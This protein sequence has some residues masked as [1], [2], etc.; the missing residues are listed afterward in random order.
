MLD[1]PPPYPSRRHI[2]RGRLTRPA[3]AWPVAGALVIVIVATIGLVTYRG[4]RH[5]TR[6]A[7]DPVTSGG[8]AGQASGSDLP[9]AAASSAAPSASPSASRC[10][11]SGC[12]GNPGA[13]AAGA[14]PI[15]APAGKRWALTFGEEF[16]G[17]DYDHGKLTPCFDWNT[18]ECT[19]TFNNG[20]EAYQP[21]QVKVSNG[22][23]KLVAQ[24]AAKPI[25]SSSCQGG[26]CT[27]VAGLLST[28]RPKAAS[29]QGYL[30]KFTYGF[31]ES[32]FKFPATR[33]FFT[34]FWMLPADPSYNYR[35]E[36]DILELLGDDPSTMFMT[37][38]YA[39]RDQSY[40]VNQGKHNNGA[41]PVKDYSK[42]FV[43]MGVDWEPNRIAWYINGVKC[44]EYTDA[45][46]IEK[47]PMQLILHMM[48]DNNWQ[49]QW[50]VGLAD[51]TL[52]RQLEVDY[53]RVYQQRPA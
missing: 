6:V 30:Y 52:V 49:R 28:A 39:G 24:P 11:S 45:S 35:T 41:C 34:A 14:P 26:S 42:D 20:R 16:N 53:I 13:R 2:R 17:T 5:P 21:G 12:P 51:P 46:Q 22:T 40:A 18:G 27:Y 44:A 3:V 37:Y 10:P 19:A 7:G 36:I 15:P 9:S 25:P 4:G 29:G 38:N 1:T 32:R 33:G 48:V 50:N 47:G 23:A 31:V 43:D 8:P